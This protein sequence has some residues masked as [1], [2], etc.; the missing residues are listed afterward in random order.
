MRC[1]CNLTRNDRAPWIMFARNPSAGAD[2]PAHDQP[3]SPPDSPAGISQYL[4]TAA[5]A[6]GHAVKR[7]VLAIDWI[8]RITGQVLFV[9]HLIGGRPAPPAGMGCSCSSMEVVRMDFANQPSAQPP[10]KC[11]SGRAGL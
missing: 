6:F 4:A 10:P 1:G 8:V 2:Q 5:N 11:R 7:R 3:A 9:G